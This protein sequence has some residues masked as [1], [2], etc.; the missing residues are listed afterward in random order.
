MKRRTWCAAL[1]ALAGLGLAGQ[2]AQA[3][4]KVGVVLSLTGAGASLGIPE[5]NTVELLLNRVL[6]EQ[7]IGAQPRSTG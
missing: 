7:F 5:K 1:A 4:I 3:E 2:A 6:V